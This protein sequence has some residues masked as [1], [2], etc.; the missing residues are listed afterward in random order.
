MPWFR[1]NKS[2]R[3]LGLHIEYNDGSLIWEVNDSVILGDNI[4]S[5]WLTGFEYPF[6]I[7]NFTLN[8]QVLC[9]Y[10]R[11]SAAPDFQVTIV[12]YHLI[13]KERITLAGYFDLWSQDDFF[14]NP[15]N[16]M[17]VLYSEPQI[18]FNIGSHFSVGSEFK[19]SYNFVP[20]SKRL[21]VFPTLGV[22]WEF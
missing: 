22:K 13:L 3:E 18:W 2:L 17:L 19:V 1:N 11:G 7:G 9:K 14:G 15:E 5:S 12:W 16:K 8:T 6:K 4:N 20:F 21:E 10:I